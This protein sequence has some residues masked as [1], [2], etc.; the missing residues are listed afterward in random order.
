MPWRGSTCGGHAAIDAVA[1]A[2]RPGPA[3]TPVLLLAAIVTVAGTDGAGA[4][5]NM[6]S[7]H[8]RRQRRA[9][10]RTRAPTRRPPG[11]AVLVEAVAAGN[12]ARQLPL[13]QWLEADAAA[14]GGR[15]G[16]GRSTLSRQPAAL[17]QAVASG[18]RCFAGC[19]PLL[20]RQLLLLGVL[21]L[22]GERPVMQYL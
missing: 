18:L 2:P 20:P 14:L 17:A 3:S 16:C 1:A 22:L 8:V 10:K 21:Q 6:R 5:A 4:A 15:L 9:A 13:P 7:G 12:G 11:E 19:V